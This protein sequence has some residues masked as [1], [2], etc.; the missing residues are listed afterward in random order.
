MP[1]ESCTEMTTSGL[2]EQEQM[3]DS[4]P[5]LHEKIHPPQP[6]SDRGYTLI[7]HLKYEVSL[8]YTQSKGNSW[9]SK[10]GSHNIYLGGL[11][12]KNAGHLQKIKDLGVTGILCLVEDFELNSWINPPVKKAD[13]EAHNIGVKHVPSVDFF[14]LTTQEFDEGLAALEA[15]LKEG[16]IVYVHCKAGVGRSASIVIA[17]LM[18][19]EGLSFDEAHAFVQQYRPQINLNP[20]QRQAIVDY[21][22]KQKTAPLVDS[23]ALEKAQFMMQETLSKLLENMLVYVVEGVSYESQALAFQSV[24]GWAPPAT[25]ESTLARRDRYL[26]EFQ[27][28]QEAAVKAAI[29]RSHS[30]FR[31]LTTQALGFIPVVGAPTSYSYTLWHQLREVALIAALYGHDLNDPKVKMKILGSLIE[32]NVMKLPAQTV[33]M[34]AKSIIKAALL[35]AGISMVPG[36]PAHLIFNYFTDNA[37]KVST[38]AKETFGGSHSVVI[39]K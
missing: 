9:W 14:P 8:A 21:I 34:V 22:N 7:K 37:A 19:H 33:D 15:M 38:Y 39:N 27:G 35:K 3:K 23:S 30:T 32:G 17:Y 25:V 16:R 10:I 1:I 24:T 36:L 31:K 28:D 20:A 2:I 6:A 29:D 26:K 11:P 18:K 12:L 4:S 13:W 5:A